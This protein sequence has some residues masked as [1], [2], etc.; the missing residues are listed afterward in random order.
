MATESRSESAGGP[1]SNGQSFAERLLQ[2][3]VTSNGH[4]P[5]IEEAVDE[6]DILHPPPSTSLEV[7]MPPAPILV[8]ATEPMSEKAMGK[9]KAPQQPSPVEIPPREGTPSGPDTKS[10]EL[11][12]ALGGGPK[13]RVPGPA[14]AW[15][16]KKPASI[17]NGTTNGINGHAQLSSPA[18]SRPS[19]PASGI[20]TPTSTNAKLSNRG[21]APQYMSM[22]GRHTERLT[23]A[24]SQLLPRK[25]LKKPVLDILRDINK[26][27]KATVEMK[28]GSGGELVFEGKG[29]VDAVRQA[30]KD[31]AKEVGSKVSLILL[32]ALK[33]SH[34][35]VASYQSSYSRE[36]STSRHWSPRC[37]CASNLPA[38]RCSDSSSK[39]GGVSN[40]TRG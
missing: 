38:D 23:F 11:F 4:G 18:S 9:Q 1:D 28:P 22:P 17:A 6:E 16:A 36:C 5:S 34:G 33:F 20:L 35:Y 21:S 15:G 39:S 13:P 27:S 2:K 29:P 7:D 10:E 3:H 8:P 31:V 12:P 25:D 14:P 32:E 37:C 26:R 30:L 24:P 19:T 40:S